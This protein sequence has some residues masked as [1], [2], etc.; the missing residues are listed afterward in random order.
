[1][2]SVII[3]GG[4]NDLGHPLW[5]NECSRPNPVVTAAELIKGLRNMI[6]AAHQRG[7]KA[8]GATITPIHGTYFYSPHGESV[9][10]EVNTWIRSSGAFDAVAG[11][12]RALV[13]PHPADPQRPGP[14]P[15]LTS[16]D[17]VHPNDAGYQAMADAIDLAAL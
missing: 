8:I 6:E 15:A 7:I 10:E 1:M 13:D 2:R 14:N 9:R 11:F 5:D 12:D 4:L 17:G 16:E 3:Q